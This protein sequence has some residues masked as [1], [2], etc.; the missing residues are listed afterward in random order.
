[1]KKHVQLDEAR[2]QILIGHQRII[3]ILRYRKPLSS[4]NSLPSQLRLWVRYIP[5]EVL[6]SKRP[7]GMLKI[8]GIDFALAAAE[9]LPYIAPERRQAID[10]DRWDEIRL[11]VAHHVEGWM[12]EA[13]RC[14][15]P[16]SEK[17][18]A[19]NTDIDLAGR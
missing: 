15:H 19:P 8:E 12:N 2:K 17:S 11:E 10:K 14:T 16:S 7:T 13:I 6:E 3:S 18:D 9:L 1:V 4:G 5:P